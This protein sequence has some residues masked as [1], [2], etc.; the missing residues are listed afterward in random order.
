[1][2]RVSLQFCSPVG[3]TTSVATYAQLHD[4]HFFLRFCLVALVMVAIAL[5]SRTL[6]QFDAGLLVGVS[7]YEGE[8][9]PNPRGKQIA[10]LRPTAGVFG[11]YEFVEFAA[12]RAQYQY[13]QIQ[14]ADADRESSTSRNLSFTND[15]HEAS[16]HLE[17]YPIG[18]NRRLTP[19]VTV[20]FGATRFNPKTQS[21]VG[22]VELRKVGTEGQGL[23]NAD[24]TL[25]FGEK[26]GQ[27]TAAVPIGGGLRFNL[28][29]R[30][31]LGLEAM[32]R[33]TS[34][35]YL[36]DVSKFRYVPEELLIGNGPLAV[37]LAYRADELTPG[38]GQRSPTSEDFR[39]NP[40]TNDFYLSGQV[41][42]SYRL[43]A[44]AEMTARSKRR[45]ANACPKF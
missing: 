13:L 15:L 35:D 5:P 34:T 12:V 36:D 32:G 43:G 44:P 10:R 26:Y 19:Y 20:G 37:E 14:G 25:L 16:I 45:R 23:R 9:T 42:I 24:S 4:M 6:A 3:S 38:L 1:M 31:I 40:E 39:G 27:W 41:T 8:L 2:S 17:F 22:E 33:V 21:S 11:R 29:P 28:S 18:T 7:T 30:L